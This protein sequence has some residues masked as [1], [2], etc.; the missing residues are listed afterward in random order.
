MVATL[1]G[2]FQSEVSGTVKFGTAWWFNDQ[3][4]GM[5]DQI[6]TLANVGVL[7]KLCWNANRF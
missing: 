4:D 5:E 7:A 3:R 1:A 2:N 6:K